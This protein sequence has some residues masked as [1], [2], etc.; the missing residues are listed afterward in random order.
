LF[1]GEKL[2]SAPCFSGL[3]SVT[4]AGLQRVGLT[5]ADSHR[6]AVKIARAAASTWRLSGLGSAAVPLDLCV[7]AEALGVQIDFR[8]NE[9][10]PEF[11]RVV[12]PPFDAFESIVG[13]SQRLAPTNRI[14]VVCDAIRLLKEDV[15]QEIV[16]GAFVPGPFTLLSLVMNANDVYVSLRKPPEAMK[17]ALTELTEVLIRV[18]QAYRTAGAD[19]IT[20]HEMG[21][22]PGVIGPQRFESVVLP[23]L[24]KLIAA[25][26]RPRVLSVCGNTNGMM[27]LVAQA[28]ADAISVDQTNDLAASRLAL[29]VDALLFGNI[30]PVGVLAHGSADDVRRAMNAAIESGVD[31]I[32]PGCDLYPLVPEEN[33]RAL[34]EQT[35][36]P[37]S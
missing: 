37:K 11:P 7:E 32:W 31:A 13:A 10:R 16:I 25:L 30:D 26:P 21:G 18:A 35:Q 1:N 19:F 15:G 17:H 14:P 27:P 3:I 29:G 4:Q 8:E 20:I 12:K 6:D 24:Q 34:V 2:D 23:H 22:S 9:S 33:L 36:S 28:G 5:F